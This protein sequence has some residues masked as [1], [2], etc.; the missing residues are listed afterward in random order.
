M[1]LE[2]M[3]LARFLTASKNHHA[4]DLLEIGREGRILA[5]E[6]F[7]TKNDLV[8]ILKDYPEIK[9]FLD[10]GAYT[11][12]SQEVED[13]QKYL[14]DYIDFIL[15]YEDRLLVYANL[16][17]IRNVENSWQNQKYMEER[18]TK[19]M[20]VYHYEE[21]FKWLEK[22]VNEYEYVGVGGIAKGASI[23]SDRVLFDR[24]FDYIYKRNLSVK[25]H[26]FGM[27]K[28]RFLVRY[29]WYSVD[30]TTWLQ[31]ANYGRIMIPSYNA[32][33]QKF[34][35]SYTPFVISVSN[36][37]LVKTGTSHSHYTLVFPPRIVERIEEYFAMIG[38]DSEK[39]KT[40]QSERLRANAY[41]YEEFLKNKSI[42]QS[43]EY[44]GN[45]LF[46]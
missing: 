18:G 14:D 42:C 1:S 40:E 32:M 8:K 30:S 33:K 20:P 35:Y 43:T 29:P 3:Y 38:I 21:D 16:D 45:K 46:F 26:A 34:E 7:W 4:D 19:P 27:A 5:L 25:I 28:V 12:E 13:T 36:I 24:I 44:K 39:L 6:S 11:L 2:R 17:N 22:C 23:E 31:H 37:S 15:E 10:S 9:I 41:Y